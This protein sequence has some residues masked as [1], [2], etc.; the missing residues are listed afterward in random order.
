M[1][2]VTGVTKSLFL[3]VGV[4]M[5]QRPLAVDAGLLA[6]SCVAAWT[7]GRAAFLSLARGLEME[8]LASPLKEARC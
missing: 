3:S 6:D 1:I 8:A 7:G 5:L 4:F 2:H